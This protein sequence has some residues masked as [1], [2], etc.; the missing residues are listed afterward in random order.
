MSNPISVN[1]SN[2]K[3]LSIC[4]MCTDNSILMTLPNGKKVC[5]CNF[6]YQSQLFQMMKRCKPKSTSDFSKCKHYEITLT[7]LPLEEKAAF[8][9]VTKLLKFLNSKQFKPTHG[10][11]A[12]LEHATTNAHIH[13]S[14]HTTTYMPIRDL[15]KL[16]G[17]RVSVTRLKTAID[18]TKWDSYVA[19]KEEDKF[20]F[21]TKSQIQLYL[22]NSQ[23]FPSTNNQLPFYH[24]N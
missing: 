9:V 13:L 8:N 16:N 18:L 5:P 1:I 19:K 23:F 3:W 10:W 6:Y 14:V 20:F 22:D 11:T 7:T 2:Q 15:L 24:G 4:T 21:E 12:C 17:A